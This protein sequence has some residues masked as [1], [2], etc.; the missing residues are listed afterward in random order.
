MSKAKEDR[1]RKGAGKPDGRRNLLR[2]LI[3]ILLQGKWIIGGIT[4]LA[5]LASGFS[6]AT[7]LE[8]TYEARATMLVVEP[9]I[10]VRGIDS[11]ALSVLLGI[12]SETLQLS[13]DTYKNQVK[14]RPFWTGCGKNWIWT[15]KIYYP[16]PEQHDQGDR[17]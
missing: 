1:P 2:E 12:L 10:E 17:P 3:E 5:L 9:K 4:V 13:L 7:V 6:S 8:P 11:S 15:R 16:F 14:N